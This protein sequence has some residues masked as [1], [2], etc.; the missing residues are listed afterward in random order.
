MS[1]IELLQRRPYIY[2]GGS[3]FG[4]LPPQARE[5][6][7]T[8]LGACMI[9]KDVFGGVVRILKG[10]DYFYIDAHQ[11]IYS[12]MI[13]LWA[14]NSVIDSLTVVAQLKLRG[15]LDAAGGPFY[16]VQLTNKV[17]SAAHAEY[18]A[19]Y[20]KEMW[21]KRAVIGASSEIT[22]EAY[23]DTT[24]A[25]EILDRGI[26]NYN[27]IL[28]DITSGAEQD[29]ET[30][31]EELDRNLKTA[32]KHEKEEKYIIGHSTG[33]YDLDRV[34][35]GLCAPDLVLM[36][37]RPGG[38]K[39]TLM[40]QSV[41]SN[42]R[43]GIPCGLFSLE[44]SAMQLLQKLY[45][46]ETGIN[47]TK[48]R[49]GTL[50]HEEWKKYELA[51]N[52]VRD[53]PLKIFDKA[54]ISISEIKAISSGWVA[55]YKT[56]VLYLDYIQLATVGAEVKRVQN[57]EQEIGFI[58]RNLKG[59]AKDL[60]VPF[61]ALSQMSRKIEDRPKADRR[62]QNDDLRESGSLEQDADVI[63]FVFR[64]EMHG[65]EFFEGG[66]STANAAEFIVAKN[67]LG[68]LNTVRS[69]FQGQYSR[70]V[71]YIQS[72]DSTETAQKSEDDDLPF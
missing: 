26:K 38:G 39:T 3:D 71:Q 57:R 2:S 16:V 51:K 62:P 45:S 49:S 31:V 56:R 58:S 20:I 1:D 69:I 5:L 37:G 35:L 7:E 32:A 50:T 72:T 21:V 18:H 14:D 15:N 65:I 36:A 33:N 60:N 40:L 25:F 41:R 48:L 11:R 55:K 19:R 34:T 4:K 27:E 8:V 70:F 6:E 13:E 66:E 23:E 53:W 29:M 61:V 54:G 44:M 22:R 68:A 12:A 10:P 17:G 67:R 43:K 52:L 42:V 64:P 59:V 46:M 63:I 24:D 30:L 28:N 47:V 9:E